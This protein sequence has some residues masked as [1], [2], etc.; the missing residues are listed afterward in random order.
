[1]TAMHETHM[2]N[3]STASTASTAS[4]ASPR[5]TAGGGR[6]RVVV[7]VVALIGLGV[8]GAVLWDT[9]VRDRLFPRR[10]G[11]VVPGAVYRAAQVEAN[12]ADDVIGDHGI[13][14][15]VNLGIYKP[16]KPRHDAM[17]AA[18]DT[19][20]ASHETM[21]LAGD[22]TGDPMRYV[23][24]LSVMYAAAETGEPVL[25][26]CSAG[27]NRTGAAVALYRV[28]FEGWPVADARAEMRRYD[29]NPR[30]NRAL[31]PYLDAH[32]DAIA[33]ALVERGVLESKPA[34]DARFVPDSAG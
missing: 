29:F 8:V 34:I 32:I 25:V 31:L 17:L 21:G 19:Y 16:G 13:Q 15:V 30:D 11:E 2:S 10:F 24:T 3:A 1:M 23:D 5:S 33:A 18:F 27:V 26:H 4:E 6:R 7:V 22:G 28:L 9:V 12:L 20:D 14:H